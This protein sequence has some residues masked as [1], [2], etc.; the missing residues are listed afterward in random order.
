M[1]ADEDDIETRLLRFERPSDGVV[2]ESVGNR[3]S[4]TKAAT[5][6]AILPGNPRPTLQHIMTTADE[7]LVESSPDQP[8]RPD[9]E[10][11]GLCSA[12]LG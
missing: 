9:A 6:R 5:H 10:P 1:I 12:L 7:V 2:G 8:A 4:E 3:Q 11:L